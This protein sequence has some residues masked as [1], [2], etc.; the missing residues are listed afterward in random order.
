MMQ[1]YDF[2]YD[3]GDKLGVHNRPDGMYVKYAD[4]LRDK[5]ETVVL[6]REKC[7]QDAIKAF[8][9]VMDELIIKFTAIKAQP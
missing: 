1:R 8:E 6:A 3:A 4:A 7:V 5:E 2:D 9:Q